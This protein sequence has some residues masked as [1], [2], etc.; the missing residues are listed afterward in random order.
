[1]ATTA[2]MVKKLQI[3]QIGAF[4]EVESYPAFWGIG[5]FG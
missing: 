3:D 1:M 4:C 2:I 5:F